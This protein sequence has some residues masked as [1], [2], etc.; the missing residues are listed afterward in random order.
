MT[1]LTS[2]E[3]AAYL[4]VSVRKLYSLAAERDV[5]RVKLGHTARWR[6]EDLDALVAQSLQYPAV[7]AA[8]HRVPRSA[9]S[10]DTSGLSLWEEAQRLRLQN[11]KAEERRNRAAAKRLPSTNEK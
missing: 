4:R 9:T 3:A 6:R 7:R 8:V 2:K 1:L 11:K 5:P 10:P